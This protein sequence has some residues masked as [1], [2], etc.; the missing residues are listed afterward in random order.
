MIKPNFAWPHSISTLDEGKGLEP[1]ER[2]KTK[3][4]GFNMCKYTTRRQK[5]V[6]L[7]IILQ[8]YV[9][10]YGAN[11]LCNRRTYKSLVLFGA[12]IIIMRAAYMCSSRQL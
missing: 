8:S 11:F 9:G 12:K 1:K 6:N 2:K 4:S 10:K 7:P 3:E 5:G